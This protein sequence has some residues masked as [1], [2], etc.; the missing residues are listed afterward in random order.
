MCVSLVLVCHAD[1]PPTLKPMSVFDPTLLHDK[2]IAWTG[3][4]E[5]K[6][7]RQAS[8]HSEG[9]IEWDGLLFDGWGEA[10]GG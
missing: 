2:M 4:K 5:A 1:P 10:L 7:R 9:V 8:Q 6:W 3:E